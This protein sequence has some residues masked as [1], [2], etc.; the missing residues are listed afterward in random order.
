MLA[1]DTSSLILLQKTELLPITFSG[2]QL[3][4]TPL[5]LAELRVKS[6]KFD[7]EKYTS[8]R[9][10]SEASDIKQSSALSDAD[11]SLL[12][13]RQDLAGPP[14]LSEDGRILRYCHEQGWRHYCALSLMAILHQRSILSYKKA[15][16]AQEKLKVIGRYADWVQDVARKMLDD[17]N[18]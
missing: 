12:L 16:D 2:F 17:N 13:L 5:I 14:I 1:T 11:K 6:H 3:I 4:I 10:V 8:I 15:L 7:W 9:L 18:L